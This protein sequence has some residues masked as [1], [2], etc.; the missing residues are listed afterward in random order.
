MAIQTQGILIRM[1]LKTE[2]DYLLV[3]CI[4]SIGELDISRDSELDGCLNKEVQGKIIGMVK[5]GDFTFSYDYTDG[6]PDA[7]ALIRSSVLAKQSPLLDVQIELPN[8]VTT[9]GTLFDF[10]GYVTKHTTKFDKTAII[11]SSI[12]ISSVPVVTAAT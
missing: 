2:S 9:A 1:K 6:D 3:G 10:E 4:K 7:Q 12:A 11:D 8:A 5:L